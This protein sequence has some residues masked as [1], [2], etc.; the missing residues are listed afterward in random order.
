ML[1][2][3]RW[4]FTHFRDTEKYRVDTWNLELLDESDLS[5]LLLI[6]AGDRRQMSGS[7]LSPLDAARQIDENVALLSG[8]VRQDAE[9]I[10]EN[11]EKLAVEESRIIIV[12]PETGP[13]TVVDGV[14]RLTAV[15]LY[16]FVRKQ[17]RFK[18]R[19]VYHGISRNPYDYQFD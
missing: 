3:V 13:L 14:H 8:F 9:F 6:D 18:A 16:Y 1:E 15:F 7:T 5:R 12:G 4:F 2:S 10:R 19:E 11:A 17:G